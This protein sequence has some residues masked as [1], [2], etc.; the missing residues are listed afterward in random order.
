RCSPS[1]LGG[2]KRFHAPPI[3]LDELPHVALVVISHDHYYHLYMV[4][5]KSLA[6]RGT[7]CAV[8]IGIGAHLERWQIP[9][10]QIHELDWNESFRL[11]Q[12]TLP[13]IT[14]RHTHSR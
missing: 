10:A 1:T 6:A 12:L 7:H 3:A 5:V 4:T 2:P 11:G 8:P 14:S 13:H 9:A